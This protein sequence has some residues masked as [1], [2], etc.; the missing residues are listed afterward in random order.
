[1][2][3][4]QLWYERI[5]TWLR[6]ERHRRG[7]TIYDVAAVAETSGVAVSRWERG[8]QRMKAHHYVALQEEG[9]LP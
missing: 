7:W 9:L 1:M 6:E 2:S 3:D 4:A 8:L 5:G